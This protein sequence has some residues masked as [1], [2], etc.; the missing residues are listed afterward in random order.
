MKYKVIQ[1]FLAI[2]WAG[3]CLFVA[4]ETLTVERHGNSL[5]LA[6]N[7]H[8]VAPSKKTLLANR[9]TD[10]T[11]HHTDPDP[12]ERSNLPFAPYVKRATS[13][14]TRLAFRDSP[15]NQVGDVIKGLTANI[16]IDSIIQFQ[17]TEFFPLFL[18]HIFRE[19]PAG[20]YGGFLL[21]LVALSVY[22][23]FE[24]GIVSYKIKDIPRMILYRFAFLALICVYSLLGGLLTLAY[25]S[26]VL[27]R[28][29]R[30]SLLTPLADLFKT[31]AM[32]FSSF[33]RKTFLF[34]TL[35]PSFLF[36]LDSTILHCIDTFLLYDVQADPFETSFLLSKFQL[37]SN[38][39]IFLK[40]IGARCIYL[41]FSMPLLTG[42]A[43]IFAPY[44]VDRMVYEPLIRRYFSPKPILIRKTEAIKRLGK[45]LHQSSIIAEQPD[46]KHLVLLNNA[47]STPALAREFQGIL[48]PIA[49]I[50]KGIALVAH[51]RGIFGGLYHNFTSRLFQYLVIGVFYPWSSQLL[52]ILGQFIY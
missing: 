15:L 16:D 30:Q 4:A 43:R 45:V 28:R 8:P 23:Y 32:L 42:G 44:K 51:E 46:E 47:S 36:F 49:I 41:M 48:E 18:Y 50:L 26:P 11:P 39:R 17:L 37:G 3:S 25:Q 6:Q 21:S 29:T 13:S 27:L 20:F 33:F 2:F 10:S 35:L 31:L 52:A 7:A 40:F 34:S 14:A 1:L 22:L 9:N 5:L 19:F 24:F 12:F 38:V